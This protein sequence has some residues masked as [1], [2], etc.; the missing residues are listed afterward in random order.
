MGD[1]REERLAKNEALFREG[2]ERM[3]GWEERRVAETLERYLCECSDEDCREKVHLHKDEYEHIRSNS[4]W[5]VIVPGHEVP[6]VETVL[7]RNEGWSIIEKD[8]KM[9]PL[10]EATDPR[11]DEGP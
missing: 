6:D 5:F 4:R 9:D 8:P 2:N 1:S 10:M 11:R 7:E 3:A